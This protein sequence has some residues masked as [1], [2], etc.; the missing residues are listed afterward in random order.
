MHGF[1][2]YDH[3]LVN[4]WQQR[5]DEIARRFNAMRRQRE[6]LATLAQTHV[7]VAGGW[8]SWRVCDML[9]QIAHQTVQ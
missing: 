3:P 2:T 8:P 7:F 9:C 4:L 5:H 6:K 1:I